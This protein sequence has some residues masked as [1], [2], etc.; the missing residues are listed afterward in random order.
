ME[1]H[2]DIA[3]DLLAPHGVPGADAVASFH[4]I[5]EATV[6]KVAQKGCFPILCIGDVHAEISSIEAQATGKVAESCKSTTECR[7]N[8][9]CSKNFVFDGCEEGPSI[10][11]N[12]H[13]RRGR[14]RYPVVSFTAQ[15]EF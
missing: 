11:D 10:K 4:G 5:G 1:S 6:V 13:Q 8:M 15:T 7:V 12:T 9:G 2:S 14:N 3:Y